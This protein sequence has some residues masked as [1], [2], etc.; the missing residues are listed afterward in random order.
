MPVKPTNRYQ[1]DGNDEPEQARDDT[2][3]A[4]G[5]RLRHWHCLGIDFRRRGDT[6]HWAFSQFR[7]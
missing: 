6:A 5:S 2:R 7:L 4:F 3:L 1:S